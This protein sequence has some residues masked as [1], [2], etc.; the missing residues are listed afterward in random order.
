MQ[1]G[2][3]SKPRNWFLKVGVA[4]ASLGGE[5]NPSGELEIFSLVTPSNKHVSNDGTLKWALAIA[6]EGVGPPMS[7]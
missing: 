4:R 2:R 3:P 7:I 5:G 1:P 6:E